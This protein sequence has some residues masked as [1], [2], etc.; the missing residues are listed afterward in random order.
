MPS[1]DG[2]RVAEGDEILPLRAP[3]K[4][5]PAHTPRAGWAEAAATAAVGLL[6]SATP[7]RFDQ[8]EWRW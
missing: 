3:T 5:V 2:G 1:V 6:D 4:V 7:T 8:D